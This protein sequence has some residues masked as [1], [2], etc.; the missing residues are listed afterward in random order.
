V[1]EADRAIAFFAVVCIAFGVFA[2][3]VIAFDPLPPGDASIPLKVI[4]LAKSEYSSNP[5]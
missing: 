2:L 4:R 3:M 1:N 5:Q